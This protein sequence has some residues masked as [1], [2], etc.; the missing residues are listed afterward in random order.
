MEPAS[1][2]VILDSSVVIEAGR[3]HLNVAQ[4]LKQIIEKIG[5]LSTPVWCD[6]PQTCQPLRH[7]TFSP[8]PNRFPIDLQ[9]GG[10]GRLGLAGAGGQHNTAARRHLLRGSQC[11][12][13][14]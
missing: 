4:F 14:L 3:Q 12:T 7:E 1:L 11:S 5:W 2:G 6:L 13:L 8:Q 9:L 10:N